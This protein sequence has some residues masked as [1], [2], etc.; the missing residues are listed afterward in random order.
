[1]SRGYCYCNGILTP[2][3]FTSVTGNSYPPCATT[4]SGAVRA[5]TYASVVYQ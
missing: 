5:K 3:M 1:M 4:K 2:S